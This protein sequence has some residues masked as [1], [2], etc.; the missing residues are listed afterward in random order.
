MKF[1]HYLEKISG[2]GIFP[3]ISLL[4]F[5]VFFMGVTFYVYRTPKKHFQQQGNIPLEQ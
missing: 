4:M 3:L 2:V 5:V 1:I